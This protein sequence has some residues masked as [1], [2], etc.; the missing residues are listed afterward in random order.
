MRTT[1]VA[2]V[3]GI[4]LQVVQDEREQLVAVKP[5]CEILGVDFS[6]QRAKLKE[7][8]IFGSTMVLSTTVG[9]DGKEREMVCIPLQFFPGWL[10]S[11]NPDNVKEE[12]RE[13]LI[14]YQLECNKVLFDYFFSRVDFSRKKEVAVA[15]A[16]EILDEK[17]EQLKNAKE[18]KNLAETNF[19]KALAL[20][21]EEWQADR[22]QLSI[23]GFE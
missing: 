7:H 20:T 11:I 4:S 22:Q 9:A 19:N 1:S 15:K 13:R 5:V 21:F 2:I 10:F 23:P 17:K 12:A 3:N 18:E 16:K 14:E 8:P 6:A